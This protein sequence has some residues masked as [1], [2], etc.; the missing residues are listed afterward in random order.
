MSPKLS[1]SIVKGGFVIIGL[2]SLAAAIYDFLKLERVY[3]GIVIALLVF[4]GI[5]LYWLII[6]PKIVRGFTGD[7]GNQINSVVLLAISAAI[8]FFYCSVIL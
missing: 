7:K 8:L 2:I 3:N 4:L 5:G 1:F 6:G